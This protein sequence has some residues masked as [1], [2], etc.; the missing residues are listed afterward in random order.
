MGK[1]ANLVLKI[2]E[3]R[4]YEDER[5]RKLFLK[6]FIEKTVSEIR[7]YIM[8]NSEAILDILNTV[9]TIEDFNVNTG[10]HFDLSIPSFFEIDEWYC[11]PD[12][13]KQIKFFYHEYT[14]VSVVPVDDRNDK[15][16]IIV[17]VWDDDANNGCYSFNI[18]D[19]N[20]KKLDK[21]SIKELENINGKLVAYL[22]DFRKRMPNDSLENYFERE[23]N[24]FIK[25]IS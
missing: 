17:Q 23:M 14:T 2:V 18:M 1:I 25:S 9:N 15:F 11:V 3:L 20:I 24:R 5:N 13:V 6:S 8:S 19:D 22:L 16:N 12:I 4:N 10:R 21:L 7:T